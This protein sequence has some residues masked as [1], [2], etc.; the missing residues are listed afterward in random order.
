MQERREGRGGGRVP[1]DRALRPGHPREL[2]CL[3]LLVLLTLT[4]HE[5]TPHP[6]HRRPAKPDRVSRR[7]DGGFAGEKEGAP[8][9]VAEHRGS[10][11][12]LPDVPATTA[13]QFPGWS[14][15]ERSGS[16]ARRRMGTATSSTFPGPD[17]TMDVRWGRSLVEL[18]Y[19]GIPTR[20]TARPRQGRAARTAR[21]PGPRQGTG[22]VAVRP[23]RPSVLA[24]LIESRSGTG[25]RPPPSSPAEAH[26]TAATKSRPDPHPNARPIRYGIRTNMKSP[27]VPAGSAACLASPCSGH[28]PRRPAPTAAACASSNTA[29]SPTRPAAAASPDPAPQAA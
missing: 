8:H 6:R 25:R 9:L 19:A 11:P 21:R 4:I 5:P 22:T 12:P 14:G 7:G 26:P 2:C 23:T 27:T 10:A 3:P 13:A 17:R 18:R 15:T 28:T 1:L 29:R 16:R 20:R 24:V